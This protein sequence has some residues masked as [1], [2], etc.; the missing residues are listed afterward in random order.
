[1]RYGNKSIINSTVSTLNYFQTIFHG[2]MLRNMSPKNWNSLFL[3]TFLRT[4]NNSLC[5]FTIIVNK[6]VIGI[7]IYTYIYLYVYIYYIYIY[8]YVCICKYIYLSIYLSVSISISTLSCKVFIVTNRAN[9]CVKDIINNN[10]LSL[11]VVSLA[12]PNLQMTRQY[13][14]TC[15]NKIKA[16][17]SWMQIVVN[18]RPKYQ[19]FCLFEFCI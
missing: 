4:L 10:Q 11:N 3:I 1:M 18:I 2:H 13:Y 8:I 9:I 15:K 5:V 6:Y 7:Y 12:L 14:F 19:I 17:S 16:H